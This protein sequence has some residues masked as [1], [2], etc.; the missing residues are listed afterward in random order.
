MMRNQIKWFKDNGWNISVRGREICMARDD[1]LFH[2]RI[3][4]SEDGITSC[5]KYDGNMMG[6]VIPYAELYRILNIC[7]ALRA[8]KDIEV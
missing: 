4:V 6:N 1:G 8:G 7:N 2:T 5:I 3:A